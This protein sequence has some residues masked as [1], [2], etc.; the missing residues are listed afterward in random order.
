MRKKQRGEEKESGRTGRG[1]RR[2]EKRKIERG[3]EIEQKGNGVYIEEKREGRR[4]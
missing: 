3:E 1:R 2:G 4:E